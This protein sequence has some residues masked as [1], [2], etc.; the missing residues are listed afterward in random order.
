M[1]EIRRRFVLKNDDAEKCARLMDLIHNELVGNEDY[2]NNRIILNDSK[3]RQDGSVNEIHV[4]HDF[5]LKSMQ[6]RMLQI[7]VSK[8]IIKS[9]RMED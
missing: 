9:R 4:Y 8:A 3:T 1:K 6:D 2:I 7:A 5:E